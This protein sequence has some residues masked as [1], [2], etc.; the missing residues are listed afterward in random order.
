MLHVF[1]PILMCQRSNALLFLLFFCVCVCVSVCLV[2]TQQP[3]WPAP[4]VS[5]SSTREPT[6]RTMYNFSRFA[7]P[8]PLYPPP[9]LVV[10]HPLSFPGGGG[11]RHLV[12]PKFFVAAHCVVVWVTVL[13]GTATCI[14]CTHGR[15]FCSL[16]ELDNT[17]ITMFPPGTNVMFI[18]STE[19]PVLVQ[20]VGHSEHGDA[21]PASLMT[22]MAR[23]S[24]TTVRLFGASPCCSFCACKCACTVVVRSPRGGWGTVTWQPS[25]RGWWGTVFPGNDN[26]GGG[27]IAPHPV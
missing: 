15:T 14:P 25:P 17:T 22:V 12:N 20:V 18:R 16:S 19:E 10:P 24:C 4:L 6:H 8:Q 21:Y 13:W 3:F 7:H 26:G 9:P 2:Q 5:R 1:F 23:P 27:T 11:G